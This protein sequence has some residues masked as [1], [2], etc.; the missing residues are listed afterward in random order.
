T[1]AALTCELGGVH[2]HSHREMDVAAPATDFIGVEVHKPCVCPLHDGLRIQEQ[3]SVLVY[4]FFQAQSQ[5]PG[6]AA[7]R[8]R[9]HWP[10]PSA[11][12]DA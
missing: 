5:H 1:Q 7:R 3:G 10:F 12:V 6:H 9:D 8:G 4:I 2:C 11:S